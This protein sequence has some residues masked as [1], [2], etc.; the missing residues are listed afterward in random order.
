LKFDVFEFLAF[1]GLHW[2]FWPLLAFNDFL[3]P[4]EVF[5]GIN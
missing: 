1:D 2:P 3:G 4:M 5:L